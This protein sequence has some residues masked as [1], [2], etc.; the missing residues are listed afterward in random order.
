MNCG[1]YI[2]VHGTA[3]LRSDMF[4]HLHHRKDSVQGGGGGS[5][6]AR[7]ACGDTQ[8]FMN[9]LFRKHRNNLCSNS[10]L[11]SHCFK[12]MEGLIRRF[13]RDILSI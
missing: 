4:R 9:S 1:M 11:F 5:Q 10:V 2:P 13:L 7:A 6:G 3:N 8:H 12:I